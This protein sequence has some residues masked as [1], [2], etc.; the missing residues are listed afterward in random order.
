MNEP[1]T[2]TP[3][4]PDE[5]HPPCARCGREV[6]RLNPASYDAKCTGCGYIPEDCRCQPTA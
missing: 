6:K 5:T 2:W 1:R 3:P 4:E